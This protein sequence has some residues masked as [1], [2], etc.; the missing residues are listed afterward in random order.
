MAIK[1]ANR[2]HGDV[3]PGNV[4]ICPTVVHDDDGQLRIIW[5]GLL[6]DWELSKPLGETESSDDRAPGPIVVVRAYVTSPC[7][8]ASHATGLVHAAVCL[9]I[10]ART[11]GGT[12]R[13]C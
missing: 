5:K 11:P 1:N 13:D 10:Q 6:T 12:Y 3:S 4:L 2:T 9:R 7:G 8:L